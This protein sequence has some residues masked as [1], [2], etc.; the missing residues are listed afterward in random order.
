LNSDQN[1][2]SHLFVVRL[3]SEDVRDHKEWCGRI[4]HVLSGEA[5]TFHDW[6]S[7]IELLLE[8]AE[9]ERIEAGA[10]GGKPRE[11]IQ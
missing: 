9:T 2:S 4:Q 6:P 5:Y 1:Q 7:L 3:W 11:P 8:M 10:P